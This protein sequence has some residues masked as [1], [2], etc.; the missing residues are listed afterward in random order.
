MGGEPVCWNL[1]E[2]QLKGTLRDPAHSNPGFSN[3]ESESWEIKKLFAKGLIG[4]VVVQ[5]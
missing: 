5:V 4:A 3:E 2:T 1:L